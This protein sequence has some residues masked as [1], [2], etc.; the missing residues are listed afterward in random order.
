MEVWEMEMPLP[1]CEQRSEVQGAVLLGLVQ[2]LR[3]LRVERPIHWTRPVPVHLDQTIDAALAV[4]CGLLPHL[5]GGAAGPCPLAASVPPAVVTPDWSVLPVAEQVEHL[6]QI[7][8]WAFER[9]RRDQR[10]LWV[11]A[12]RCA[13]LEQAAHGLADC[14]A[15]VELGAWLQNF[16][17]GEEVKPAC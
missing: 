7:S 5:C 10:V 2:Y 15:E 13:A 4:A 17:A 14:L 1:F 8:R 6:R 9:Q 3:R 12:A 11:W 16:R